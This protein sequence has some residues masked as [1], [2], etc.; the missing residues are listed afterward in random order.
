MPFWNSL[1]HIGDERQTV[2]SETKFYS[3]ANRLTI[4][5]GPYV[6]D[7]TLTDKRETTTEI[8]NINLVCICIH[9]KIASSLFKRSGSSHRSIF[10]FKKISAERL[11]VVNSPSIGI[12]NSNILFS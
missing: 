4:P 8:D 10:S 9:G 5:T 7:Y 6:G 3:I 11:T 1:L 2:R 12:D